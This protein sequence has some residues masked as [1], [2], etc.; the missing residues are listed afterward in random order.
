MTLPT[1]IVAGAP[2]CG[3]TT[4]WR[5]LNDHPGVGMSRAKEPPFFIR[6]RSFGDGIVRPGPEWR[7]TRP[8]SAST[9]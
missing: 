1:F 9:R 4:L 6:A 7:P 3:T 2:K 5:F 8:S